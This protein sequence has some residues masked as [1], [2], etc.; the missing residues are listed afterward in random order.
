MFLLYFPQLKN[1]FILC[2]Y[3]QAKLS[4][5]LEKETEE[6]N[7]YI[8]CFFKERIEDPQDFAFIDNFQD[9]ERTFKETTQT[10]NQ[11]E[12][13]VQN[14]DPALTI[15]EQVENYEVDNEIDDK[16]TE[17]WNTF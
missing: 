5:R 17:D 6:I 8:A 11:L 16:Y 2:R 15:R 14:K 1:I 13:L 9:K 10:A 7:N 12:S 3:D 4:R